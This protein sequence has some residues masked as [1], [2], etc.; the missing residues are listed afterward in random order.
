[1]AWLRS[2]A[3][4]EAGDVDDM[5]VP[6]H[7]HGVEGA[8]ETVGVFPDEVAIDPDS[9]VVIRRT[10]YRHP[11]LEIQSRAGGLAAIDGRGFQP[12]VDIGLV[13]TVVAPV[14]QV[15]CPDVVAAEG[16]GRVVPGARL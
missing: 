16:R 5:A 11:A 8:Y 15:V 6:A 14:A 9:S 10:L 7:I 12:V 3:V 13:A 2:A 4:G 1:M